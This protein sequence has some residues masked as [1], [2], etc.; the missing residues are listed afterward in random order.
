MNARSCLDA[1]GLVYA[2]DAFEPR[3]QRQVLELRRMY[4]TRGRAALAINCSV[5]YS[6]DLQHG[7]RWL[8]CRRLRGWG[9]GVLLYSPKKAARKPPFP[10]GD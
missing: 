7:E 1:N 9:D 3:K 4:F 10:V 5:L 6:E 8:S 2:D